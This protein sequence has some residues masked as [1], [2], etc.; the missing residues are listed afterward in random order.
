M[1]RLLNNLWLKLL[2]LLVG[3]L[4]WFHVVTEKTYTYEV[5]L[6]V[7]DVDLR[8]DLTLA[9]LP[10]DSIEI[11]VSAKGKQLV[12]NSWRELGLRINARELINAAE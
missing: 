10:P 9:T 5:T 11:I 6:P 3:L 2:A 4:V 7:T 12:Q 8:D 1:K